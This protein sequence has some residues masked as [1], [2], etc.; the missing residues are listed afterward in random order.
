MLLIISK[1]W[2]LKMNQ[3]WKK[4]QEVY[5]AAMTDLEN[6]QEKFWNSLSKEDQLKAFCAVVRRIYEGE[7][8]DQGSY[9]YVLYDTF[10]FGVESYVQAQDAGYLEIHNALCRE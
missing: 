7:M 6:E 3:D 9:R 5:S 4:F 2:R 1:N 8:V 10:G